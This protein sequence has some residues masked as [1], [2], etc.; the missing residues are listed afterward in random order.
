[1]LPK[2]QNVFKKKNG[3][4]ARHQDRISVFSGNVMIHNML[5]FAV[6]YIH[7]STRI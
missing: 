4:A 7:K 6:I 3:P 1:M 5:E 2:N